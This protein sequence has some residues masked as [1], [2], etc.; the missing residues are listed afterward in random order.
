MNLRRRLAFSLRPLLAYRG[1][2]LLALTGVAVG[3]AAVIVSRAIG[4]GAQREMV[5][6][7]ERLGTN[8]LLIKPLPVK[9]PVY[10][11]NFSG[12]ATSLTLDDFDAIASLPLIAAAAPACE[13]AVRI[14][15]ERT[16]MKATLRGTSPQFLPVRNFAIAEGR[17]FGAD[18]NHEARRVVVLGARV[19]R[20]LGK[21]ASMVGRTVRIGQVPFEVIGVL[22]EKG[23]TPDGANEDD[24]LLA[25]VNTAMRRVF[26][27]DWLTTVYTQV[28][29]P[30]QMDP[31]IAQITTLL[32]AR[33]A[34][35]G[36]PND[37]A[38][39]NTAKIRAFQQQLTASFSDYATWLA[40]IA[41]AIGGLGTMAL[42][43]LSV[44]ERTGEIGLRIAVG[45]EPRDIL[46]QFLLEASA[47]AGTGW[48]VGCIIAAIGALGVAWST[49]LPLVL[50]L[51]A[52]LLS[53]GAT[54]V[55]GLGF[56]ALP[57]RAAAN[58]PPIQALLKK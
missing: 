21:G 18:D 38:V 28:A 6:S 51:P 36:T 56:G 20:E 44:R 27:Q 9:R 45:A 46:L 48:I 13:G 7:V 4:D 32:R 55:I 31:A 49:A 34:Q 29:S 17:F 19:N 25:P 41:L 54:A 33:H 11:P 26:N 30:A 22:R 8:L 24:Y 37:F 43:F 2:T 42:M 12:F 58:I 14:H 1:R 53:L 40:S 35:H 10:R 52:V 47:L 50:P 5:R 57:A 16:G 23:T 39:Q 3:V 15:F